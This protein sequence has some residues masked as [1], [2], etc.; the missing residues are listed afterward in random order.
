MEA[1]TNWVA[2]LTALFPV[3]MAIGGSW[4]SLQSRLNEIEA[5]I[6]IAEIKNDNRIVKL[7][8]NLSAHKKHIK[9]IDQRLTDYEYWTREHE[10]KLNPQNP[11]K[12][13]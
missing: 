5:A 4:I 11:P 1:K 7:E 12:P 6:R 9:S 8:E 3:L 2:V 10:Q 13:R